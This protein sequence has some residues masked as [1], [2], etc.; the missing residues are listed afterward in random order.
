MAAGG[1][2]GR[3]GGQHRPA[4][5]RRGARAR[6]AGLA[7]ARAE[8]VPAPRRAAP[9]ARPSACSP[10]SR[11]TT[12][13]GIARWRS[14]TATRRCCSAMPTPAR[15]GSPTRTTRRCRRWSAPV[16]GTHLRFSIERRADGWYDRAGARL[17]LG[18]APLMPRAELPLL[19]DHNVANALAAALVGGRGRRRPP[20]ASPPGSGRSGRF[21]TGSSRSA[22]WTACSGSTTPSPP[23]S[24]RPRWRSRRST[25]RSSC[26]SGGRHKGE[27][28]TRL[29][30]PLQGRCRAVVAYGEAGP[31]GRA[32][33]GRPACTVVPAGDFAEVLATARAAGAARRRGAAVARPAPAT[34]C[35]RTTRSAATRFRA[36]VEAM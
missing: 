11:P 1:A 25:G 26:C 16:P 24:P 12:S 27:P 5:L 6:P 31:H 7:R 21:P 29:A 35:S 8:L 30:E 9:P 32:G 3:D 2:P 18:D 33:S 13:T 22:R 20:S 17:M 28:Y 34:T 14:T 15:C 10:T 4:A 23:T 36:A 19:G